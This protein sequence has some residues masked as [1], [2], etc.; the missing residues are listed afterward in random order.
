MTNLDSL[1][2]DLGNTLKA[3]T[4]AFDTAER[5]AETLE[6]HSNELDADL[7]ASYAEVEASARAA[8]TARFYADALGERLD[9]IRKA[10]SILEDADETV[11]RGE[12]RRVLG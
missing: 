3:L 9:A 10:I 2:F 1:I 5:D 8:S 4:P 6:D 11:R 12:K 7:T